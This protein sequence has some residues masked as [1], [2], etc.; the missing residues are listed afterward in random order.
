M[1]PLDATDDLQP[2]RR[3]LIPP[4]YFWPGMVVALLGLSAVA[5][6]ITV[7]FALSD[8][9]FA[10]VPDYYNKALQW[11]QTAAL[12]QRS[13]ALQWR[14]A[15]EFGVQ[16][17]MTDQRQIIVSLTGPNNEP[18]TGADLTATVFHPSRSKETQAVSFDEPNPGRYVG[19]FHPTRIGI[20]E[21]EL[22][23][24][25]DHDVFLDHQQQWLMSLTGR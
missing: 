12:Q 25:R 22:R 10:V 5:I 20:W 4:H 24:T 9:S 6:A 15:F 23:A 14:A 1:T 16:D 8:P 3:F 2:A 11:D 18:I 21:L 13:D 19:L 17:H 7:T